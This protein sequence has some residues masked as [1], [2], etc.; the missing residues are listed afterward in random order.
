MLDVLQLSELERVAVAVITMNLAHVQFTDL[1]ENLPER[2]LSIVSFREAN[3]R[4]RG[5]MGLMMSGTRC[6]IRC[7]IV[8]MV[9]KWTQRIV[10]D[11][12]LFV[13]VISFPLFK[14]IDACSFSFR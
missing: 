7:S 3:D 10:V 2:L 6:R 14:S 5:R 1:F 9:K 11:E 12:E 8:L 13:A 4:C